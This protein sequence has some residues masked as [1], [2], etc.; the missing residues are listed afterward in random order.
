MKCTPHLGTHLAFLFNNAIIFSAFR[1]VRQSSQSLLGCLPAY[2]LSCVWLFVS[3]WT[4][5]RQ[6]PQSMGFL[7]ARILIAISFSTRS[8]RP[9]DQTHVS[10][11]SCIG[12]QTL[13]HWATWG[14]PQCLLYPPPKNA[15]P[16]RITPYS[17]PVPP[18]PAQAIT[19][20]LLSLDLPAVNISYP[21]N[22]TTCGHL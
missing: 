16:L 20:C 4:V 21:G 8:S 2:V 5:A 9:R 11:V 15:A 18:S 22:N 13:H 17:S 1:V 10:C 14:A 12:R 19:T 6:A 7:Q 3:P